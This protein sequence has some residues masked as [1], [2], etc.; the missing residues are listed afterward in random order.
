MKIYIQIWSIEVNDCTSSSMSPDRQNS[1]Q[2]SSVE[3][4]SQEQESHA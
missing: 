1:A 3:P 4:N 2:S